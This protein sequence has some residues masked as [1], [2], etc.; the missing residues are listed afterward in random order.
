MVGLAQV[1]RTQRAGMTVHENELEYLRERLQKLQDEP[2]TEQVR[3]GGARS[4][5]LCPRPMC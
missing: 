1:L 5:F 4:C 2:A 3:G